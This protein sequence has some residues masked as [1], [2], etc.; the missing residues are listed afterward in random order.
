MAGKRRTSDS[1]K[2]GVVA[3]LGGVGEGWGGQVGD[4]D[5]ARIQALCARS[6]NANQAINQ[7]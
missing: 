4:A 5:A 7:L 2:E 3:G 6:N 1:E